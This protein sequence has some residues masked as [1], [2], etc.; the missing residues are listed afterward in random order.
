M[1]KR[2]RRGE[3]VPMRRNGWR[4]GQEPQ[5]AVS[6]R[7]WIRQPVFIHEM[8][9]KPWPQKGK[10]TSIHTTPGIGLAGTVPR[11]EASLRRLL[12]ACSRGSTSEENRSGGEQTGKGGSLTTNSR[13]GENVP[14]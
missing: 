4:R 13:A 10:Q 12:S 1:A 7:E 14:E 11:K 5:G 3:G 9:D 2:R 8:K 6:C